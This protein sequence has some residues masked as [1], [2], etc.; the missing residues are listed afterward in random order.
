MLAGDIRRKLEPVEELLPFEADLLNEESV[1]QGAEAFSEALVPEHAVHG[2]PALW[3]SQGVAQKGA[4]PALLVPD[5]PMRPAFSGQ[6]IMGHGWASHM[7]RLPSA[8][9]PFRGTQC[10]AVVAGVHTIF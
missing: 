8:S 5:M 10:T 1:H 6:S 4:A 9:E 2:Q 3:W 7:V